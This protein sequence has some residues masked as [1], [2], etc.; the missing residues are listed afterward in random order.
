MIVLWLKSRLEMHL[1]SVGCSSFLHDG[2]SKFGQHFFFGL[3]KEK[4]REATMLFVS[5]K[6]LIVKI[7]VRAYI[8]S[9]DGK[10]VLALSRGT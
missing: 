2:W 3:S 5:Y 9:I 10:T 1:Q 6:L 4:N 8:L 7:V